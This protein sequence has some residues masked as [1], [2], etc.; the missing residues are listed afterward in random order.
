MLGRGMD[1]TKRLE[2]LIKPLHSCVSEGVNNNRAA[3]VVVIDF[4][5]DYLKC[6]FVRRKASEHDPWSGQ[7]A[8]PGGRW[9]SGDK[10]LE[11]T[12]KRELREETGLDAGKDV[13][14]I[15]CMDEISPRN[16]PTLRVRPFIAVLKNRYAEPKKGDEVSEVIWVKLNDLKP[17]VV[18]I[19]TKSR[20]LM[21]APAY[22]YGDDTVIWGMTAKILTK[23]L[24]RLKLT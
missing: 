9:D 18:N 17:R 5:G 2:G 20:G 13:E 6:L 7:V 15:G 23:I 16:V 12:V 3:V 8:F 1:I 14:I 22:I 4:E 21:L 10:S 24:D 19:Y 11:D